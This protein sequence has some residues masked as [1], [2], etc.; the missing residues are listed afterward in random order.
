MILA[1][2]SAW[3]EY[4]R[5]TGSAVDQRLADLIAG[6][7]DEGPLAVTEPVTMEVLAGARTDACE[8]DLRRL[9]CGSGSSLSTLRRTTR[10]PR[11]STAGAEPSASHHAASLTA[12][13][14][15]WPGEAVPPCWRRTPICNGSQTS[16]GSPWTRHPVSGDVAQVRNGAP[17][18]V[19]AALTVSR[20]QPVV[21]APKMS[22]SR[23]PSF[24]QVSEGPG[25]RHCLTSK[26]APPTYLGS[27]PGATSRVSVHTLKAKGPTDET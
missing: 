17:M 13:S 2:T 26:P 5:A 25:F 23:P 8:R 19:T 18:R 7:D 11:A 24:G 27:S 10:R 6:I 14:L 12:W 20:C 15:P 22:W 4:D 21:A 1:D 16:S 3:V 9:L